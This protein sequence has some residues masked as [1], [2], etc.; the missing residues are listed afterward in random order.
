MRLLQNIAAL[1]GRD[2]L[3]FLTHSRNYLASEVVIGLISFAS[4]PI[5][6]RLLTK[7][8]YGVLAVFLSVVAIFSLMLELNLRGAINRYWLEHTKDFPDFLATNLTFLACFTVFNLGWIWLVR[9]PLAQFFRLAPE[10]FYLAVLCSVVRLPWNLTWK[11]LVAQQRSR[12]FAVLNTIRSAAHFGVGVAW[13]YLLSRE[14]YLGQVYALLAV[15]LVFAIWLGMWLVQQA[16]GGRLRFEHLRY[17][18]V[19]GVPLLPHALSGFILDFF[20]RVIVSQLEGEEATGLYSLAYDV[21]KVMSMIVLSTNQSWQPIFMNLRRTDRLEAIECLA[22]TYTKYIAFIAVVLVLFAQEIVMALA[23]RSFHEALD[24][25]PI[26]VFGY[27]GVYLYTLYS[28]YSFYLRR[29]W[30]ISLATLVA[31]GINIALN[32]WSIPIWGYVAAAWTTLVSYLLLFFFHYLIARVALREPVVKLR[33]VLPWLGVAA[34][35]S[36][37]FLLAKRAIDDYWIT[38]LAVKLPLLAL[39]LWAIIQTRLAAMKA[40]ESERS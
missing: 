22:S 27:V 7:A 10:V 23:E 19:F 35:V 15:G 1:F 21:G 36:V 3:K 17:A 24:L 31:G 2:D 4:I 33:T 38:L 13:I 39:I 30:L 40:E 11:L 12:R 9:E 18:L 28:S 6:T 34:A 14:R 37:G 8:E 25:V 32:Y 26:I 29:T 16:R 20:D 5:L